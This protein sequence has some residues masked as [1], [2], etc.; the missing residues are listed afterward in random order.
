MLTATVP[1]PPLG[2]CCDTVRTIGAKSEKIA[3]G[4]I[5]DG[6]NLITCNNISHTYA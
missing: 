5:K 6:P 2:C 3:N 1:C 4:S